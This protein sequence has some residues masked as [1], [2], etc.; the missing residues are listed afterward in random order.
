MSKI[1]KPKSAL[2]GSKSDKKQVKMAAEAAEKIVAEKPVEETPA[3]LSKTI[4][5]TSSSTSSVDPAF[6]IVTGSYEHNLFCVSLLL[7]TSP[8]FRPFSI[9]LLTFSP[10]SVWPPLD[11]I[12]CRIG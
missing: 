10:S 9:L 2:K 4:V 1:T 6:R 7:G 12:L 8:V 11:G 5:S 3:D